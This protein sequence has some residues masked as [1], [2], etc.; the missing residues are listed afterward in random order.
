[1]EY[2]LEVDRKFDKLWLTEPAV[3]SQLQDGPLRLKFGIRSFL[4]NFTTKWFHNDQ[5]IPQAQFTKRYTQKVNKVDDENFEIYLD[6]KRPL[7][8]DNAGTYH[9]VVHCNLNTI[10]ATFNVTL[11]DQKPV[12][13]KN[14]IIELEQEGDSSTLVLT[15]EYKSEQDVIVQWR[16]ERNGLFIED[17]NDSVFEINT[18]A[19]DIPN[20]SVTQLR[21]KV[22][23][24]CDFLIATQCLGLQSRHKQR[25]V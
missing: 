19:L 15:V 11:D 13:V 21:V 22:S 23:R 8:K 1:V 6:I 16:H 24:F 18:K 2:E 5:Q 12:I 14:P 3:C 4:N 25:A 9:C 20:T 10:K 17:G 7:L